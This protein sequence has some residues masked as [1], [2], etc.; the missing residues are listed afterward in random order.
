MSDYH[1][2]YVQFDTLLLTN[3]FENF[4]NMC[5]K[6]HELDPSHFYS[7]PGLAWKSCLKKTKV[8]LEL[9]TNNDMFL[10]T[11]EGIRGGICQATYR[12]AKA[13]N[14]YMENCNKSVKSSYL[15]Y[16]DVNNLYGWSMCKK[17]PVNGFKWIEDLSKFTED[18]IKNV[19]CRIFY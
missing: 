5:I 7:L 16:L 8:E 12:Y 3:I 13:N 6:N 17:L 11:E 14:K 4:R 19:G 2:L 9:I 1:N 10:M 18:F 15:P